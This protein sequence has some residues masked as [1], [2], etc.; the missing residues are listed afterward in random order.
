MASL[1]PETLYK[2][3]TPKIAL[4]R[5]R[6]FTDD[7]IN[8]HILDTLGRARQAGYTDEEMSAVRSFEENPLKQLARGITAGL[9][10]G[11][12]V[13]D[14]LKQTPQEVSTST[15]VFGVPVGL[16]LA[17]QVSGSDRKSVV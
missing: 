8:D 9:T 12:Y 13:P 15:G 6:G 2:P 1:K 5:E 11:Y 4:W 14:F 7:E 17:G 16:E 3:L 10:L